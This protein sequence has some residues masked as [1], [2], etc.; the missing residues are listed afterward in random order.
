MNELAVIFERMTFD[1]LEVLEAAGTKWNFLPFRPGLVGGHCIGVDPYYLT[2]KAEI[3]GYIPQVILSG[4]R[5]NDNMGRYVARRSVKQLIK[6]GHAMNEA[7]AIVLGFT[8]KE[9][10]PDTRNSKVIDIVNELRDYNV[11]VSICDPV[12]D[13]DEAYREYGISLVDWDSLPKSNLL[14][15][16]VSHSCFKQ[17]DLDKLLSNLHPN[18]VIF[19]VKSILP[20]DKIL[21]RGYTL[22]RL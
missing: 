3:L 4:R 10:C 1:T 22:C 21:R 19:D 15:V 20:K 7:N 2:Y 17:I 14:I 11:N 5:I 16:A 18:A 9:D 12:A 8:F 13:K 6:T